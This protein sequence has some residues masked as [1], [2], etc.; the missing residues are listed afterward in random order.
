MIET[1]CREKIRSKINSLTNSEQKVANYVLEHYEKVLSYNIIELS[2]QIGVSEASV[3]RFCKAIGYKGYQEFKIKAAIDILPKD[4]HFN[5]VLEETDDVEHICMKIF[6]SEI[7]ALNQTL[8]GLD[9]EAVE[10]AADAIYSANQVLFFGTGGSLLVAQDALHKLMK[11]GI[12]IHV[13][14]DQDLQLMSSSLL[15]KGDVAVGIS[16]SGSNNHVLHCLKNAKENGAMTIALVGQGRT[17]ISKM[18]DIL[19]QT[20]AEET[21]F[22][23]E[24]VTT[25]ITQLA[26]IDSLVA[27][28]AFKDYDESFTAIQHTRSATSINKA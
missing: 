28:I 13:H 21:I 22:Q 3:V 24:S 19:L 14:A 6:R 1:G 4:K 2:E 26:I 20:T 23:S 18:A 16:H 5:P 8:N 10:R 11:I 17:A 25:R 9:L 7:N 15:K 12:K 27:V